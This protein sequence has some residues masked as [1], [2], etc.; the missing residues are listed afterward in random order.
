M[1]KHLVQIDFKDLK[2]NLYEILNV[3]KDAP[4]KKI[5][6]A[7]KKLVI[8]FHPDKNSNVEVEIYYHL[9]LANQILT[10]DTLRKKYDL[11]L[12][13]KD[14]ENSF[15]E[16]KQRYETDKN[17]VKC[18]IPS[19]NEA[20]LKYTEKTKELEAK[21]GVTSNYDK[22]VMDQ[23]EQIKKERSR[24]IDIK[25][26]D[27]KNEE[28]FNQLFD[29][30]K[31]SRTIDTQLIKSNNELFFCNDSSIRN[32]F[33]NTSD[34]NTLYAEDSIQTD[35]YSSLDRAFLVQPTIQPPKEQNIDTKLKQYNMET[36]HL[37]NLKTSQYK[38]CDYKDWKE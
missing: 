13:D 15:F 9:T 12:S 30:R 24:A 33:A 14:R 35:Q 5:K 20:Q 1:S 19:K 3:Q 22:N 4:Q 31:D 17:E 21:H 32:K 6:K 23:L 8:K 10:N 27:L 2:F 26:E 37:H 29:N 16:L 38:S 28:E 11:W 18:W 7:Y 34:Y 36:D 25:R